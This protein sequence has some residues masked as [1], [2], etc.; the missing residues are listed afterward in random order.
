VTK[1]CIFISKETNVTKSHRSSFFIFLY[2]VFKRA[3]SWRA[4]LIF[5]SA[6]DS[7]TKS[8]QLKLCKVQRDKFF[9]K[10][11]LGLWAL[12]SALLCSQMSV[13]IIRVMFKTWWMTSLS[14]N[15]YVTKQI[16]IYKEF[17]PRKNQFLAK[18][19]NVLAK[20]INSLPLIGFKS[21][22]LVILI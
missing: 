18:S 16:Y 1:K 21:T 12:A 7:E 14:K 20:A 4:W 22:R 5:L 10:S 6:F 19:E 8:G 3:L 17:D 11:I 9:S 2:W 13:Y 15:P